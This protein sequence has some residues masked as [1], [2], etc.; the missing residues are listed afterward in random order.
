MHNKLLLLLLLFP[1]CVNASWTGIAGYLGSS[2]HDWLLTS[3]DRKT[4]VTYYG[5]RIEEK[6]KADIRIGAS[7]AQYDLRLIDPADLLNIE[8]FSGERASLYLRWPI[9]LTRQLKWHSALHFLYLR[10]TRNN[11]SISAVPDVTI[12]WTEWVLDLGISVQ[13]GRISLRPF[14]EFRHVDGDISDATGTA[15]FKL[16]NAQ[17][18]GIIADY[19]VEPTAYVRLRA[20]GA[21]NKALEVSLVREF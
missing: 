5:L 17:S 20:T 2:E 1:L 12:N 10:G 6:T 19:F 14:V 8:K 3:Q 4:D 21:E 16:V 9:K 7:V 15:L 13:L 18:S 11:A